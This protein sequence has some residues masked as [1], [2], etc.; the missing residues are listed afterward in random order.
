[1]IAKKM[2]EEAVET[3]I[4]AVGNDSD[5][6]VSESADL[7]YH[8]LVLWVD[9]G[10][11]AGRSVEKAGG[12]RRHLGPRREG[13]AAGHLKRGRQPMSYDSNNVFAK[14]LRGEIPCTRSTRTRT[15]LAF[16]DIRPQA[17]VHA[18][19]IP[20]GAYVSA[21]DFG[22]KASEKEIAAFQ[23][24]VAKV[25]EGPRRRRQRL[26]PDRQHRRPRPPGSAALPRAHPR[27]PADRPDGEPAL[28][29]KLK[30]RTAYAVLRPTWSV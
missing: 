10:R 30:D 26:P 25:A 2:G 22:E 29:L 11:R 5:A 7:I 27:R 19:V 20:K 23:R 9:C 17:K 28:A 15:C 4:A 8:L 14:I 13:V 21:Q 18:L 16:K 1:V 6:V 3:A 12:A 24:A